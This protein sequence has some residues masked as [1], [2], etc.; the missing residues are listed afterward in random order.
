M[1]T[2]HGPRRFVVGCGAV[3]TLAM[4]AAASAHTVGISRG[5]YRITGSSVSVELVFARQELIDAFAQLD[6]NTDGAVSES[7]LTIARGDI[8]A[9][10]VGGL[11]VQT[12]AGG[13]AGDLQ[14]VALTDQDGIVVHARFD[15][16]GGLRPVD[17]NVTFLDRLSDGHRHLA[18][19]SAGEHMFRE[20]L[21]RGHSGFEAPAAHG[22][23]SAPGAGTVW[24]LFRLGIRHILTGYDH[25]VF[26]FGLILVGGRLRQLL[27]VITSF[28]LAHS[29]TLGLA[30]FRIWSPNAAIV[31]PAIAL[32][33]AYIGVEN[34]FVTGASR[35]WLITFSFGLVHG[36]GFA[37]ALEEI[38]LPVRQIPV[39]LASFNAGVEAGQ[40]A[41][42][43]V[44]LPALL[45]VRQRQWLALNGVRVMS[46]AI[47]V[48]GLWW[49][50]MRVT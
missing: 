11:Q 22:V 9:A 8:D 42:L 16:A 26:L 49:F 14:N 15:C 24:P 36:F 30:A 13:C 31:E 7:E 44:V 12:V 25:L 19:V 20:V 17:Y 50:A 41:V 48:A 38:S 2:R 37:G 29:I 4:T 6:R 23:G 32:S 27:I 39:A 35:R 1:A 5:S 40:L 47:V 10:I 34:W 33:I 3:L 43:A 18:T 28:T 46:T 21:Y 45:Y